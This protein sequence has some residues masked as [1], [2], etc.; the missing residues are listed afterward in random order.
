MAVLNEN[1]S[2]AEFNTT[3]IYGKHKP[4]DFF[5]HQAAKSRDLLMA[6]TILW[7]CADF[8][9]DRSHAISE[10]WAPGVH[11]QEV[12]R[13]CLS[14]DTSVQRYCRTRYAVIWEWGSALSYILKACLLSSVY[15]FSGKTA[16]VGTQYSVS[17][18][19]TGQK[20]ISFIGGDPQ[21]CIPNMTYSDIAQI[22]QTPSS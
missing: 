15:G 4:K 1:I 11:F 9:I 3:F 5:H 6:G 19:D 13:R 12:E 16:G 7:K 10:W 20:N 21:L 22:S 18:Q 17:G 2:L 8:G 14:L